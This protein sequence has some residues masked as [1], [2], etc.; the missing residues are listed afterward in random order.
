MST[1]TDARRFS[2]LSA[3]TGAELAD[4]RLGAR[5]LGYAEGMAAGQ[6]VVAAQ[7][8]ATVDAAERDRMANTQAARIQVEHAV[9][10]LGQAVVR[11][12][13]SSV[14]LLEDVADVVLEAAVSL[15]RA[16]LQA[17]LSTVDA[18]ALAAVRRSLAPLPTDVAVTVRLH[19]VDHA[20]VLEH[21][22]R[23]DDDGTFRF[24]SHEVRIVPDAGLRQ[25]DAVAEQAG[26]V[27]DARIETALQRA[28][29]TIRATAETGPVT[30]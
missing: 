10:S 8:Q 18:A 7:L 22:T 21:E 17:E 27:V 24:D 1:S 15:A 23:S 19:P 11:M 16:I 6:R 14:P 12:S 20:L 28:L 30:A 5:S 26:S 3:G 2:P 29:E 9:R 25:G 4:V 13:A